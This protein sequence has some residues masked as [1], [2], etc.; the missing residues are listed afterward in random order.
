MARIDISHL[1]FAHEGELHPL[2]DDLSLYLDTGWKLGLI[3]RNGRGKT[4][5]L[6]LLAGRLPHAGSI[7]LPSPVHIFP[8]DI[9]DPGLP[10]AEL[11]R[12]L[13]PDVEPWRWKRELALLGVAETESSAWELRPFVS[14]SGGERTKTLLAALFAHEAGFPLID[15]PTN[16]LDAEG[17]AVLG[18]YLARK[19]GFILVSHDRALLDACVDHVLALTGHGPELQQGDYS[20]WKRNRECAEA[21][22]RARHDKLRKDARRLT[23]AARRSAGWSDA[24][25]RSKIGAHVFDR[26]FVG[27]KAAKMMKRA[28]AL[29]AR[30]NEAAEEAAGLLR[31]VEEREPLAFRPLSL[32]PGR[33]FEASGLGLWYRPDRPLCRDLNFALEPGQRLAV[34][35]GNGSGKSTLLRLLA[36]RQASGCELAGGVAVSGHLRRAA[37]LRVSFVPQDTAWLNGSPIAFVRERGL[38]PVRFW[39]VLDRLGM[40]GKADKS[41]WNRDLSLYS[42]GQK[43]KTLLAAGL[44]AEAHVYVWDEPL[45]FLDIEAREQIESVILAASP[46]LVFVEHDR[47]FIDRIATD[48][49]DL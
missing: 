16:H 43:K 40:G 46:T 34:N 10:A 31:H 5:L 1:T 30:R 8:P 21:C 38:D 2:F 25:E 18:R 24:T 27:H 9:P 28:K 42:D 35:G 29:E 33:V 37:G 15:E 23:E 17:R 44:C 49:L 39:A 4:T 22:E 48:R 36:G 12:R 45:N 14:L 6:H 11:V 41:L 7:S 3:G 19:R 20:A 26:G 47:A 32:R 13:A